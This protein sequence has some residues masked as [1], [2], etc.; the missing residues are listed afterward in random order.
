MSINAVGSAPLDDSIEGNDS[1]MSTDTH[2]IEEVQ[3]EAA[4]NRYAVSERSTPSKPI[5]TLI[6]QSFCNIYDTSAVDT[7][8]TRK[9]SLR[10]HA[11]DVAEL[12]NLVCETPGAC[13]FATQ[14]ATISP[15]AGR[16]RHLTDGIVDVAASD[17]VTRK[18]D[19]FAL[20]RAQP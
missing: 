5:L 20:L 11:D 14:L 17:A 9:I 15:P 6:E 1:P 10:K 12:T 19:S 8:R 16:K 13:S 7:R 4:Y 2:N 3:R 18:I